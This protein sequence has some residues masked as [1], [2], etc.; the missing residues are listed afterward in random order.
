MKRTCWVEILLVSIFV[1]G[2][3]Y[4]RSQHPKPSEQLHFSAEDPSVLHPV[5]IPDDVMA[6]L[7][8]DEMVRTNLEDE[9]SPPEKLPSSWFS[10]SAVH[11][12]GGKSADLVVVANQPLAGANVT[13]FWVFRSTSSGHELV[14]TAPAHDLIIKSS[15]SKEYRDIELM[16][17]TA[18]NVTS[19]VLRFDGNRYFEYRA[20]TEPIR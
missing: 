4:A 10:A 16:S 7:R 9:E 20:K 13:T 14:L 17:A 1:F 12:S 2:S 5:S 18:V 19:I 15:R 6:M 3:C 11:L 8:E